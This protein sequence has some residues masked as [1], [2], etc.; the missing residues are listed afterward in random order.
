MDLSKAFDC[1][2][3]DLL[4]AKC[5]TYGFDKNSPKYLHFLKTENN[6]SEK[7]MFVESLYWIL[8]ELFQEFLKDQ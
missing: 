5:A 7:I 2:S 1:I 6:V 3:H 4:I 8:R